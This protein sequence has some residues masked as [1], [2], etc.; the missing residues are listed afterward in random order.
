LTGSADIVCC[1]PYLTHTLSF[2][3]MGMELPL[4][5]RRVMTEL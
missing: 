5:T 1:L 3:S 2:S 4:L